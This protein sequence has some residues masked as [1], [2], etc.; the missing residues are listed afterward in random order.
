MFRLRF[1]SF[2]NIHYLEGHRFP[3][4]KYELLPTITTRRYCFKNRFVEPEIIPIETVLWDSYKEYVSI[5]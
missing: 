1:H 3:M 4:L 5:C 2:L